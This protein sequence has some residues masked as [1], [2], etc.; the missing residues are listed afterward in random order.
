MTLDEVRYVSPATYSERIARLEPLPGDVLYSREGGI[1]G[2]ACVIPN[3]LKACLGQRMMQFRIDP[4]IR[5]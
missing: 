3:G 4:K 5:S 1:L 2:L